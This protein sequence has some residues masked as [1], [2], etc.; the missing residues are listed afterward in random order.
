MKKGRRLGKRLMARTDFLQDERVQWLRNVLNP[1]KN[2][3]SVKDW[4]A[5]LTFAKK[6]SLIGICLPEEAPVNLPKSVLLQWIGQVQ[7]IE[8]Q[9]ILLNRRI[10]QLFGMLEHDGFRCCLLK[11]QGN[12]MMYPNPLARCSGDID[13]WID[14]DEETV[15]QYVK[16]KFPDEKESHKHIHFP[17]FEDAPVDMHYTP[18]KIYHPIHNRRL[19][20]WLEENKDEQMT[21]FIGLSGTFRDVAVPTAQ[22][23][24]VYQLG[25]IMI[26]IEDEGIGLR[27]FVDYFYVLKEMGAGESALKE[28]IRKTWDRLGMTKLARA[29]MWVEKE[30]LGL[31][32]E[33][34]LDE[35][36]EK[37]GSLLAEDILEGGNFGHSSVREKY[38][39]HGK[40]VKKFS[41]LWHLVRLSSCFSGDAFFR[42][43]TK[44]K[45]FVTKY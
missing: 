8:Q 27:Q 19:Q 41:D 2:L 29:V 4:S 7:L 37:K 6:Q 36:D 11:G 45:T 44:I 35:P 42:I 22:F 16:N 26:H 1:N 33:Y 39:K 10:E 30:M 3:P 12:A 43:V 20:Q 28:S 21:H 13:V 18:L 34:L 32:E 38:R 25:H 24:A 40:V 14:A 5:L 31:P 23:N 9:N 17:I 15:Y